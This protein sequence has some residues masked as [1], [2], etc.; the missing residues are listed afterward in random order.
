[1]LRYQCETTL[2]ISPLIAATTHYFLP[3]LRPA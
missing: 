3:L 1:V 2:L